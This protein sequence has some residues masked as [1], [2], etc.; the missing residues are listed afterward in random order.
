MRPVVAIDC[1]GVLTDGPPVWDR[2]FAENRCGKNHPVV[3]D[4]TDW[5]R[6]DKLCKECWTHC[7]TQ[8][9]ILYVHNP[10]YDAA[11]FL[12]I[13]ARQFDLWMVTARPQV[14]ADITNNWL[15]RNGLKEHFKGSV[16]TDD[17]KS[18]CES[19]KAFALVEDGPHNIESLIGSGTYPVIWDYPYN[20]GQQF[21]GVQ[22]VTNWAEAT[23]A[24]LDVATGRVPKQ[25]VAE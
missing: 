1:D 5:Y 24:I 3:Y 20:R 9:D 13:L 17:K 11:I 23:S 6:Y 21:V 16:F 4:P 14:A 7:L 22:R 19:L 8:P 10:R 12:P 25:R 15:S 2:Y 18:V